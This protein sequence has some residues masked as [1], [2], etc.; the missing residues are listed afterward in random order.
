ME[1][2]KL[3]TLE[4]LEEGRI[5]SAE[6]LEILESLDAVPGTWRGGVSLR[7]RVYGCG[8]SE[9]KANI[10]VPLAWAKFLAP[11]IEGKL[12]ADLAAK[13]YALD[14]AKI[15]EAVQA[16]RPASL[17]DVRDGGD[18]VEIFIE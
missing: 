6:A 11:F 17:V 8:S 7:V 15:H 16:A 2:D 13:G 1:Q 12:A 10:R 18:R 4:L 5:S 9:P 3:K 14:T